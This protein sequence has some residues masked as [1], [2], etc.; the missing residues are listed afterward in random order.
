[1]SSPR[2]HAVTCSSSA[3]LHRMAYYEWGDPDNDEVVLCVHGLTRSGRDFD[4][5]AQVLSTRYRVVCPD[6]VGRGLSD[7]LVN[8]VFY[9][10]PQYVSDMV[11][12]VARMQ[13]SRLHWVGTSMGGLI[14]MVYAGAMAQARLTH[15]ALTPSQCHTALPHT[16]LRLDSIVFNDVGPHLEPISLERIGQY[17][18]EDVQFSSFDQAVAYVRETCSSFGPHSV[19]QWTELT[20]HVYIERDGKWMKHYDLALASPFKQLTPELAEQGERLLWGAFDSICAP[21]QIIRGEFSDLLSVHTC[22]KMLDIH[23]G[24]RFAQVAGVGHAPTLMSPGQ[25]SLIDD[26]LLNLDKQSHHDFRR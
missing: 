3:G 7:W 11:T 23:P 12:L 1:M 2:L 4:A 17:V 15:A 9:A 8:P 13:P 16:R 22:E 5:L 20:R 14:G 26:F 10:I 19:E 25:I 21:I 6:V 24:T 18:G